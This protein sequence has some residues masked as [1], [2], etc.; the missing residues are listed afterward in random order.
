MEKRLTG[1]RRG[2]D[3]VVIGGGVIGTAVAY[4]LAEGGA[5][6][7]LIERGFLASGTSGATM[8]NLSL[9]NSMPGPDWDF[10]MTSLSIY[11]DLARSLKI[12]FEFRTTSS[13][14]LI[15]NMQDIGWA[16]KRVITQREAG[17]DVEFV[18]QERLKEI[19]NTVA[20]DIAGAIY[21]RAS[22]RL[23]P[24]LFCRALIDSA[25]DHGAIIYDHTEVRTVQVKNG[26][27]A[28]VD[29]DKGRIFCDTL[30]DAAGSLAD[31]IA[32]I[33]GTYIPVV[34]SR[35]V[36]I[37]TERVPYL[38][39]VEVKGECTEGASGRTKVKC[40][41]GGSGS[42]DLNSLRSRYDIHM[43]YSQTATGNC[44]I[45]RSE[46][47]DED[48]ESRKSDLEAAIGISQRAV[49]FI[50]SLS[51]ISVI[52]TFTGVRP[53]SPDGMPI[54]GEVK[55][56]RGFVAACGFGDNGFIT[57]VAGARLVAL[58]ILDKAVRIS[59]AFTPDRFQ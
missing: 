21:C 8:A 49:R 13:L 26:R 41:E 48:G 50:P 27:V 10:T 42:L 55:E 30:V 25:T 11:K 7:A 44:L 53:F 2:Y 9:H 12:D 22:A 37:V 58:S 54:L 1:K 33:G 45:G 24:F 20:D 18:Q 38:G 31:Q 14:M 6:V 46:A 39:G 16:E 47:I 5:D 59:E 56:P 32:F 15:E 36:L 51:Q 40:T 17:L 19:D 3:V 28:G 34:R 52:R 29:T 35:G 43:V 23:N 57:G 4:Y